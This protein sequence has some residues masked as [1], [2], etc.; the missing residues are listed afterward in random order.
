MTITSSGI[1][2]SV[3]R[4]IT[5]KRAESNAD[6]TSQAVTAG[7]LL[8]LA[9]SIP[10]ALLTLGK[11]KLLDFLFSDARCSSILAIMI[12]GLIFTSVYAVMR[13][14]F[15]GNTRFLTYSVIEF[16]EEAV[17]TV[18][19]IILVNST[20]DMQSGVENAAYA[21][22]VSYLFSFTVSSAVF[23]MRGGRLKRCGE[24][25]KPLVKSS[26][27]VTSMRTATSL[28][29]TLI[30]VLL[31]AR[32]IYYGTVA[33]DAVTQFGKI[34]GMA[35]PLV[36]IP[37]TV[38]GSLAI[39]LVPE[40]SAN[41]YSAKFTTLKNN[42]EK[43]INFSVFV[44]CAIIP[45]FVSLGKE[46]GV[47][48]YADEIAGVYVSQSAA[49]MLPLSLTLITTSML[50]SLG[51]E[52]TTL[53]FYLTG[54][55]ATLICI[56][57]LPKF[58][59]VNALTVGMGASHAISAVLNLILIYRVSPVKPKLCAYLLK[60]C[61]FTIPSCLFGIFLKNLL[62]GRINFT[63]ALFICSAAVAI[64]QLALF[65]TFDMLGD[66][67]RYGRNGFNSRKVGKTINSMA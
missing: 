18:V 48:L 31:P 62:F 56:Y 19:G 15:W 10:I 22:L 23:F 32:L 33:S 38:I 41:Y 58:L 53:A 59:G 57:F 11:S 16:A 66:Y 55:S 50:N 3:S 47:F 29:N 52:K 60:S 26:T 45:V 34:F 30:A 9:L 1:P 8:S 65:Y 20:T 54:A 36:S 61:A 7:I 37:S 35:I 43:A 64:F 17:M 49:M 24:Y 44:A 13:G 12:P 4:I 28:I 6:A 51:H 21:V 42:I 40:L 39:V 2:I 46:I 27:P 63:V 5:K 25:L 67:Q 14:S